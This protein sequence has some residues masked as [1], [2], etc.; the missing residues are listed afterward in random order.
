MALSMLGQRRESALSLIRTLGSERS[1][2]LFSLYA[3]NKLQ[4][5]GVSA[6]SYNVRITTLQPHN[7]SKCLPCQHIFKY[8]GH[9]FLKIFRSHSCYTPLPVSFIIYSIFPPSNILLAGK[10]KIRALSNTESLKCCAAT[11]VNPSSTLCH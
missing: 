2:N 6:V 3:T 4:A 5:K 10:L 1:C 9:F 7:S 11:A 8:V